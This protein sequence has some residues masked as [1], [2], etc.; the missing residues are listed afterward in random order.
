MI[1]W[2]FVREWTIH[3]LMKLMGE[4]DSY[5]YNGNPI[6]MTQYCWAWARVEN[7]IR[8]KLSE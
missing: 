3:A 6:S 5:T 7:T 2:Y 8:K 1:Y 4:G